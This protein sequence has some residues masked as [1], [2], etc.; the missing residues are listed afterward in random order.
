MDGLI[1]PSASTPPFNDAALVP[2]AP[3]SAELKASSSGLQTAVSTAPHPSK[4]VYI[5]VSHRVC[6]HCWLAKLVMFAI[7]S[8]AATPAGC[9][10]TCAESD[11]NLE[12]VIR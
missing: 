6:C 1:D 10:W 2:V 5:K 11:E 4:K 9:I 8:A 12:S 3:R 7:F